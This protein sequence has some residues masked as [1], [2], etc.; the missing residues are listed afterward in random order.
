MAIFIIQFTVQFCLQFHLVFTFLF[1]E[2]PPVNL[3]L[4]TVDGINK[5]LAE[6]RQQHPWSDT[7]LAVEMAKPKP[8]KKGRGKG[9]GKG[10]NRKDQ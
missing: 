10:K 1:P 5:Q 3:E 6:T 9:Q 2:S 8:K 7:T 4:F